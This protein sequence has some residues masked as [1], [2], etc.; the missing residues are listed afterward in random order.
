MKLHLTEYTDSM[1]K[2]LT[3][4]SWRKVYIQLKEKFFS[5]INSG[6]LK[7]Y[8]QIHEKSLICIKYKKNHMKT[9][10]IIVKF[11]KVLFHS[12]EIPATMSST[13]TYIRTFVNLEEK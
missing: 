13:E 6:I 1:F 11:S 12:T 4:D 8:I 5:N 10:K 2:E 3:T 7:W 9:E